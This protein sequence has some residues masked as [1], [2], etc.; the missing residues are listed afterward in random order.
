MV[1]RNSSVLE[2]APDK[3]VDMCVVISSLPVF[4][5]LCNCSW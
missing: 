2:Q 3:V 4:G 5:L 1:C